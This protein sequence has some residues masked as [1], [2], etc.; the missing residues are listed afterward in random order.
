MAEIIKK[1]SY[2][3]K[4]WIG[5]ELECKNKRCGCV[6]RLTK[7]DKVSHNYYEPDIAITYCPSCKKQICFADYSLYK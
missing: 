1:G 5:K 2:T 4:N 7:D 3:G 6:W